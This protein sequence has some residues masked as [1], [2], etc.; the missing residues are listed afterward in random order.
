M[1]I[2]YF[3]FGGLAIFISILVVFESLTWRN[4]RL[5]DISLNNSHRDLLSWS[6]STLTILISLLIICALISHNILTKSTLSILIL[7]IALVLVII[8]KINS[9]M[10]FYVFFEASLIPI[11]LM[12]LGWGYQ[13]ERLEAAMALIVYT[14]VASLPLLVLLIYF[15][16]N[17]QVHF[18]RSFLNLSL[19]RNMRTLITLFLILGFLVKFPI[20]SVH[21]WLPKAHVEAPV[22]G[23]MVLAA[24]LLKLGGFGLWRTLSI[25]PRSFILEVIIRFSLIGGGLIAI[26][27]LRQTDIKVLIAYSSVSHIRFVIC[28][29]LTKTI[30]GAIAAFLIIVAH[31]VSSSGI[32]LGANYIYEHSH[33]RRMLISSGLLSAIPSI[34]LIWFMVCLG[35]MGAPPTI[36]LIAEIWRVNCLANISLIFLRAFIVSSFF[37]VAYSLLIYASPNQGQFNKKT[38]I[39]NINIQIINITILIHVFYLILGVILFF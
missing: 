6:L 7:L 31:G 38:P 9:F 32:F 5:I 34:S 20:Y 14:I 17:R 36:N 33:S 23:S 28:S 21:L 22:V 11:T 10:L 35:N 24:I 39:I 16:F 25:V 13:P 29:L 12:V 30:T 3:S 8:F 2:F 19:G 4:S 26:L 18:S 27:C 1:T 15:N 37:A